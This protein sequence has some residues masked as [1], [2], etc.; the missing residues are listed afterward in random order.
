MERCTEVVRTF[1][2]EVAVGIGQIVL[3]VPASLHRQWAAPGLRAA[4]DALFDA[5]N[6]RVLQG[7]DELAYSVVDSS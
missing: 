2:A 7:F 3:G 5:R 6:T 1:A 4:V